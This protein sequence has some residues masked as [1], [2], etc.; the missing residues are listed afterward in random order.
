MTA[1]R[2]PGTPHTGDEAQGEAGLSRPAR[3]EQY[4]LSV[5][6]RTIPASF[7]GD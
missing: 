6:A 3:I 1:R 2:L 7:I 5:P 4:A